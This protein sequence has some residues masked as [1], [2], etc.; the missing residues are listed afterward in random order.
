MPQTPS[1]VRVAVIG[2]GT[3]G[4]WLLRAIVRDGERL[5]DRYGADLR[6]VALASRAD[7][8][9]HSD[10]GVDIEG[11]L[12]LRDTGT[13][14]AE[15]PGVTHW[16]TALEGIEATE[17]DVLVEVS[18]S[19]QAD[20]E[21]GLSH[22]RAALERGASVATSNKWP[23]A[24]AGVELRRLAVARGVGFRAESTVMSG[25]PVLSTLTDGLAGARP[26]RLRG[27]LNATVNFI[28]SRM[29]TGLSYVAA[30]AEARTAGLTEP[31][32]SADVDGLDS[33][34]K[35]MIL[36]GLVFGRPLSAGEVAVRALSE[37][38]EAEFEAASAAGRRI[39]EVAVLDPDAARFA[40]EATALDRGDPLFELEGTTNAVRVAADPLGEISITGPGAGPELAGQGV[41]SDLIALSA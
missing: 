3:V 4:T 34:A 9:V 27:I 2:L 25:T 19:P 10:S 31:D 17:T 8:F 7:G 20:G 12:R 5:R 14:L 21:P 33:V 37:V 35:L 41:L 11:A 28:C 29:D 15:L 32:P 16:P 36:S 6:L 38:P 24:L 26:V 18:Q 30:L 23:V 22:M 39:R 1:R 40:V 13:P